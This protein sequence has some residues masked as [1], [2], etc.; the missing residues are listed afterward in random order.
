MQNYIVSYFYENKI[1]K[2]ETRK[3]N[4]A[5]IIQANVL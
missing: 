4:N 1:R 5:K 2:K 3:N